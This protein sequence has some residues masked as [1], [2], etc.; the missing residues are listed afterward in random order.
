MGYSKLVA[1]GC[2]PKFVVAALLLAVCLLTPQIG[3]A[4]ITFGPPTD[5]PVGTTPGAVATGDF[6]ND[7]KPD[8]VVVNSGSN[9]ISILL[10]NAD[11]TFRSAVNYRVGLKPVSIAV[12]DLNLDSKKDLAVA[13]NGDIPSLQPGGISLLLGNG[14][15]TFQPSTSLA[16]SDYPTGIVAGDFDSDGKPDLA[17]SSTSGLV[18]VFLGNGD[19]TFRSAVNYDVTGDAL[20]IAVGDFN[21]DAKQDLLVT[22]IIFHP[23]LEFFDG[24]ASVLLGKGDGNFQTATE[25]SLGGA[26]YIGAIGDFNGDSLLD[27]AFLTK[28]NVSS[29]PSIEVVLGRGDGTFGAGVFV[30]ANNFDSFVMVADLNV[31]GIPDLLALSFPVVPAARVFLGQ[32]NGTFQLAQTVV[33]SR[34]GPGAAAIA[35]F[36]SDLLPDL[37]VT[38]HPPNVVSI[39]LNTTTDFTLLASALTPAAVNPGQSSTSSLTVGAANGFAGSVA[40][41]CSVSPN[42]QLAPQCSIS[43]SS[44]NPG[45]PATLTVT[46]TG[47]QAGLASPWGRAE[48]FFALW[49]PVCGLTLV[50]TV[51]A[52]RRK[53]R[54]LLGTLSCVSLCA[55]LLLLPACSSSGGPHGS[56]GTPPGTYT[57]T[58]TGISGVTHPTPVTLKVQ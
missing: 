57:I 25:T 7:G 22:T 55:I 23:T 48:L 52:A 14:D 8:L 42:L 30:D 35:D 40:L 16:S 37:A 12:V 15:G 31:D 50:R 18:S 11:G 51:F 21:G 39:L 41:S 49:L 19:G 44:V 10:G 54:R 32:G 1:G 28:E 24:K 34:F 27:L 38:M 13:F 9:D 53:E 2:E 17:I 46:T 20:S 33:F 5:Y 36:N 58:V 47:P 29:I 3:V 6:N 43:P 26:A 4:Q 56:S 45:T